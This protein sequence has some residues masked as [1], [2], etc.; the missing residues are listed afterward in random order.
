MNPKDLDQAAVDVRNAVQEAV[1]SA[2]A[3]YELRSIVFLK[4]EETAKC[5]AALA[6]EFIRELPDRVRVGPP[7]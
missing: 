2:L 7:L 5:I 1:I 4:Y 6:E 3:P